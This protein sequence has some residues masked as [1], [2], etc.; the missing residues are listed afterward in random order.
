MPEKKRE[1]RDPEQR[2]AE[3]LAAAFACFAERGF[4][5]TRMEDV[6]ARAG[7]AKGTVY[8]HFPDKERLFIELVSGIATPLLG[9]VGGMVQNEAIP[10]R[11]AVSMF[12]GLFK[13]QV[14]ETERR[15]LLRL[16]LAE[17]PMFPVVTEFYYR[18]IITKGLAII[19]VLL[20]RAAAR[21]ELRNPA[22]ADVPQLV[23]APAVMSIIWATL[24][25]GY[26]HL[27]T[28]KLFDT[29]LDTLFVPEGGTI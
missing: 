2:R 19:R 3:I 20:A 9:E 23:M 28:Q 4:A 29:F 16:I 7:I 1:R 18:E 25:E 15:H 8:L 27:D 10:A 26:E 24:F 13:H 5:A 6:A 12:Y 14:L 11:A 17:G 22:V 21:G